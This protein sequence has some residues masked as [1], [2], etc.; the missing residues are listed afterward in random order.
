MTTRRTWSW[1]RLTRP[2]RSEDPRVTAPMVSWRIILIVLAIMAVLVAAQ[3]VIVDAFL[4]D[5]PL[6]VMV[7]TCYLVFVCLLLA[8]IIWLVWRETTGKPLRRIAR[9]ARRVAAGDFSAQV[10]RAHDGPKMSEMDVLIEDFNTMVRELA[11]N[12]MLK[13]DFISN[14]SH[15]IKT[16]ISVIQSY[17]KALRDDR[18]PAEERARYLDVV[19]EAAARLSTMVGNV[20]KLSKL[21]NQQIFPE[22]ETYQL[23]EQLRSCALAFMGRWEEKD[24]DFVID[25]ADVAVRC[26]ASLMEVVW[27]NLISN[28]IKYTDP[29]GRVSITSRCAGDVVRVSVTDTGCGMDAETCRRAFER[30][31]Q[32]DTSHASEGN[33][34]GLALA[35]KVVELAG[36]RIWAESAPGEGSAFHV[37]LP[38]A[39][40]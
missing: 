5:I 24:L 7:L 26:D 36:G 17:A 28:A 18:V 37:E 6:L 3:S 32:G 12:E 34:L 8:G 15:E 25:V 20:L 19:I 10:A 33:G 14:V 4:H 22:P 27:N 1:R 11:G 40:S 31:Y 23:G 29:G 16:P 2:F 35:K 38:V 9:A 21:E 39:R 30:F 13:S